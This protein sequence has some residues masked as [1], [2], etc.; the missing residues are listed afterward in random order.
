MPLQGG[1]FRSSQVHQ[2]PQG[3]IRTS[4]YIVCGHA[5]V[6]SA[7]DLAGIDQ[8]LESSGHVVSR[9]HFRR[10]HQRQIYLPWK[11]DA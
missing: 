11:L 1:R 7:L 5:L 8:V 9:L 6:Q 10:A 2:L 4:T 3:D